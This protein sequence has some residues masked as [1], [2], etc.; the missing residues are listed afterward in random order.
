ML[1]NYSEDECEEVFNK[2]KPIDIHA[3][4]NALRYMAKEGIS[5]KGATLYI[6]HAP[7]INCA[8]HLAGIG[9]ARIVY[10]EHYKSSGGVDYLRTILPVVKL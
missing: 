2:P 6:T 1:E 9:L 4:M 3:E 8:K 10:K 7:C 5:T